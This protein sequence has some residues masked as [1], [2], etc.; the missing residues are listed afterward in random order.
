MYSHLFK[1]LRQVAR[2]L[3]LTPCINEQVSM[4]IKGNV[5]PRTSHEGSEVE[6]RY[7]CTLSLTSA[8][9]WMGN[10]LRVPVALPPANHF[11]GGC[12]D[13]MAG[14]DGCGKSHLG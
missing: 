7:G 4:D 5:R 2:F 14:L 11:I 1:L 6:Y 8:L 13:P 9:D 12:V 10:Y 3:Q